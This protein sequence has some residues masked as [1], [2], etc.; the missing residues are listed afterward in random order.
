MHPSTISAKEKQFAETLTAQGNRYKETAHK[1]IPGGFSIRSIR[2]T[3]ETYFYQTKTEK[4]SICLHFTVGNIMS[5]IATLTKADTHVSV[6]Y[7]VDRSGNI[8]ELFPDSYWSY[9]LGS[10]AVGGNAA[11]SKQSIGI[12]ISNYGPLDMKDGKLVDAYGNVYCRESETGL[13]HRHDYRGKKYFASMSDVQI[14]A[15]ASLV[16][17]LCDVHGIPAVTSSSDGTFDTPA[18]ALGFSGIFMHSNVRKDKFDWPMHEGVKKLLSLCTAVPEKKPGPVEEP[19]AVC[20]D[21][22]RSMAPAIQKAAPATNA[23]TAGIFETVIAL[24]GKVLGG[25]LRG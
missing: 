8:Y 24:L 19:P 22:A 9:H 15:T 10:G 11:V 17:Y 14:A 7:V 25:I 2:P 13:Y 18:T 4:K 16:R 12:E 5:D 20:P 23:G 21:P 1:D 3:A 6:S